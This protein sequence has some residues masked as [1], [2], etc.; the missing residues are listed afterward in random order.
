LKCEACR[1]YKRGRENSPFLRTGTHAQQSCEQSQSPQKLATYPQ[2]RTKCTAVS[3]EGRREMNKQLS[4]ETAVCTEQ[5]RLSAECQRTLQIW[6]DRRAEFCQ[7]H[8]SGKEAGD[9]LLRLQANYA[10]AYAVLRNHARN[11]SLCQLVSRMEGRDTENSSRT[12]SGGE[13][14]TC[15]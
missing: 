13:L 9:E 10:R 3:G 4:V 5:Q 7:L 11:C 14:Q 2:W 12:H 8:F 15:F 6:K 1:K